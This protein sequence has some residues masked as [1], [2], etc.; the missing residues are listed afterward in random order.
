METIIAFLIGLISGIVAGMIP[1]ISILIM[2]TLLYPLLITFD[3]VNVI[4]LYLTLGA[5]AQYFG[6]VSGTLFSIPG[7]ITALPAVTEGHA[8]FRKGEGDRAIMHAAIASFF[9]STFA[10][11]VTLVLL[12]VLFVFYSLFDTRVKLVVFVIAIFAFIWVSHNNKWL[13]AALVLVGLTLGHVGGH[14]ASGGFLA[15]DFMVFGNYHLFGGLPLLSVLLSLYV[16]PM[17]ITHM[18]KNQIITYQKIT[19]SGYIKNAKELISSKWMML[20]SSLLGYA[21]GFIPGISYIL[22][23]S[24]SYSIVREKKQKEKTY[25]TGDLDSLVASECANSAGSLSVI[26]PLLLVGV[27][28]TGSQTLIYN[29]MESS[30]T[31]MSISFFQSFYPK[32]ILAYI[33]TSFIC[34]FISGKYVN[35]VS[36]IIKINFRYIYIFVIG[37]LILILY[38]VGSQTLSEWYYLTVFAVFLPFGLALR[39][40]DILPLI[41]GFILSESVNRTVITGISLYW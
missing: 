21:T 7:S 38:Y 19:F 36:L 20:R 6:S 3:I 35:W 40:V 13:S 16:V 34:V 4:M 14:T 30:G 28:I 39:K 33:I 12:S 25:E 18:L 32:A 5:C 8:L 9:G 15:H 23:V 41:Y 11:I 26:L 1:G 27:P 31:A 2:L 10:L 17:L 22:G 24:L 29:I 37:I